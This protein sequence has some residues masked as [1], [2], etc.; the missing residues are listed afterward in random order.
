MAGL[1]DILKLL[2]EVVEDDGLDQVVPDWVQLKQRRGTVLSEDENDTELA[3]RPP[4]HSVMTWQGGAT[5]A[6]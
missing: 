3:P 2:G 5:G 6:T 1:V 4:P